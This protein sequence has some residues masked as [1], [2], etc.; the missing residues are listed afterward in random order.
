MA[1][2]MY[3]ATQEFYRVDKKVTV[4]ALY[5]R[6]SDTTKMDTE[7]QKAQLEALLKYAKEHG[8]EVREHLIFP[9]LAQRDR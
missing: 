4:A 5:V 7:V 3:A 8:F 9:R 2:S 6:N 1:T